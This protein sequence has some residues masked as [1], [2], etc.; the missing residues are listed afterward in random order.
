MMRNFV[1]VLLFILML[2]V[3]IPDISHAQSID[4]PVKGYGLS[5]GNSKNF[6]GIRLNFRDYRVEEINGI[7]I[8]L[9]PAKDNGQAIVR[10]LSL[11]LG[12]EAGDFLG[13]QI[14]VAASATDRLRGISFGLLA[15]GAG[16]RA[17]GLI[18][19]G[20]AAGAGESM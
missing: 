13:V 9:W 16:N 19:G 3:H 4:L 17:S 11:G 1:F 2:N 14:G 15:A 20:L 6:T 12:P 5:F 18:A 7:N 10:G 8:T